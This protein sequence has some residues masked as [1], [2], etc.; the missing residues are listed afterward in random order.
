MRELLVFHVFLP[1][2]QVIT[3]KLEEGKKPQLSLNQHVLRLSDYVL[4]PWFCRSMYSDLQ[5]A[6]EK[7]VEG[8]K[9]YN[10]HTFMDVLSGL[11][12]HIHHSR[13]PADNVVM[14]I[15]PQASEPIKSE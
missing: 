2:S 3:I 6:T 15:I 7:L 12:W 1:H 5:I 10:F 8:L 13:C 9:K 14:K 11:P 4:Q